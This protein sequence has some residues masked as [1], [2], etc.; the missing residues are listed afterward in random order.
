M[1]IQT[2]LE[3]AIHKLVQ[4]FTQARYRFFTEAD[5]VARFHQLL[6]SRLSDK[7]GLETGMKSVLFTENTQPSSVLKTIIP[8][9]G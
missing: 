8:W 3:T 4:E 9:P 7:L 1:I 6:E 2:L 5:A